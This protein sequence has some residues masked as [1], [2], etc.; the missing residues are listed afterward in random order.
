V[1][2]RALEPTHGLER[3]RQRRS[4]SSKAGN[5]SIAVSDKLLCSGPGRL[6]Q[7]LGLDDSHY[8]RDLC[9][10][11]FQLIPPSR[12]V[13]YEATPRVG[14]SQAVERPWRFFESGSPWISPARFKKFTPP[15]DS[16]KA[17]T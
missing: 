1:L 5:N 3:M 11:P 7:A 13:E 9:E 8:G 14:I 12:R 4:N 6:A 10:E 16:V 17:R 15:K 2:L